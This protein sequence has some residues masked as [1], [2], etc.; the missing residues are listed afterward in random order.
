MKNFDFEYVYKNKNF[1]FSIN[2][3]MLMHSAYR[4]GKWTF[5]LNFDPSIVARIAVGQLFAVDFMGLHFSCV[6][7]WSENKYL[8]IGVSKYKKLHA[9]A[10]IIG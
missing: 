7:V 6:R 9:W 4:I 2:E 10:K 1:Y 3:T 5:T 8:S